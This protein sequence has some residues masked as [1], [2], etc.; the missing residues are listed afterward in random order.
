MHWNA[1]QR[2]VRVGVVGSCNSHII[3]ERIITSIGQSVL[4]REV[5]NG[6]TAAVERSR[7]SDVETRGIMLSRVPEFGS[8]WRSPQRLATLI[9]TI[10]A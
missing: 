4:T 10:C 5:L 2:S 1:M 3:V 9:T 8:Q 7:E 6:Q